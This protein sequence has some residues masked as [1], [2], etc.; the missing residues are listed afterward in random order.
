MGQV[1]RDR[2]AERV[3]AG[4]KAVTKAVGHQATELDQ[5]LKITER[6][7][8]AVDVVRESAVMQTTAAAFQR[9]GSSVKTAT[10]K[11]LD[12]PAV[13]Y[14]FVFFCAISKLL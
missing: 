2:A 9:A 6:A 10:T 1:F 12:Q 4:T 7:G 13:S 8:H 3:T 5:K 14:S 11:V